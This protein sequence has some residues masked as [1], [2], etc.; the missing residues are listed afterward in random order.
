MDSIKKYKVAVLIPTFN[1]GAKWQ[2]L[3]ESLKTQTI[4]ADAVAIID[5]ES[6]DDT[7]ATAIKCGIIVHKIA[8]TSFTHGYAR[9]HLITLNPGYDLYIFLTQDAVLASDKSLENLITAFDDSTVGVAYG[10]QLPNANAGILEKHNRWFNYTNEPNKRSKADVPEYGFKTIF[11]SN[12][13]AAYRATAY[14]DAGG[15]PLNAFFGE[16]TLI[17]AKMLK[18][19]WKIAYVPGATAV[20][21]HNYNLKQEYKRYVDIGRFHKQNLWLYVDFGKPS[22]EGQKF[23]LS[24]IKYV[25]KRNPFLILSIA[26]RTLNKWLAYKA[27][28]KN[29]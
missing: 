21:S 6:D 16:D 27:G 11:C 22:K 24:E 2:K 20:H 26:I 1:A 17:T 3:L 7:V 12:S 15:F 19:N 4:T 14:F 25:L 8:K 28:F 5:S 18:K 13:F 29:K 9:H 23:V 10:K